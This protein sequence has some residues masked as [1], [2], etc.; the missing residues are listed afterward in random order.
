MRALP[1]VLGGLAIAIA[2][3]P[4][5]ALIADRVQRPFRG[6]V[7]IDLGAFPG[8][9]SNATSTCIAWFTYALLGAIVAAVVRQLAS[10]LLVPTVL[11]IALGGLFVSFLAS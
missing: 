3:V 5:A 9:V 8:P 10:P 4:A 6:P 1:R 2:G 11:W 7:F